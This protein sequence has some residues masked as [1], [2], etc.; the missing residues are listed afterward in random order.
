M[1]D[2]RFINII[3]TDN[4][5]FNTSNKEVMNI[6]YNKSLKNE[7]LYY[8]QII[9]SLRAWRKESGLK[10]SSSKY[11]IDYWLYNAYNNSEAEI[12]IKME[13]EKN[14]NSEYI[15]SFKNLD[16][17]IIGIK[18]RE[19]CKN[20]NFDNIAYLKDYYDYVGSD[21]YTSV[22]LTEKLRNY[23][24]SKRTKRGSELSKEFWYSYGWEFTDSE[25]TEKLKSIQKERSIWCGEFYETRGVD[26][27][28]S[29]EKISDYQKKNSDKRVKKYTSEELGEFSPLSKYYW[30]KKGYNEEDANIELRKRCPSNREFYSNDDDYEKRLKDIS[31]SMKKSW[32]NGSYDKSFDNGKNQSMEEI[33]FFDFISSVSDKITHIPFFMCI[34]NN[35]NKR[36]VY[37]GYYKSNDSKIILFEY[38]GL[39]YHDEDNDN[40]RDTNVF[41]NRTD[42]LGIIRISDKYYK[43]N[44]IKIRTEIYEAIR[45]I[46]NK[47]C[48]KIKLY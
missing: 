12:M 45:K 35:D 47:E 24:L 39:Y 32:S 10:I 38:D 19:D 27:E 36:Y 18:N 8:S 30:Y 15:S 48:K 16:E 17:F 43:K 2:K 33:E 13:Y 11:M 21:Y 28:T 41:E 25:L 9:K 44:K 20:I 34:K 1:I 26:K 29:I 46:E 4:A 22:R 3:I 42:I 31:I 14:N 6:I 23:I 7:K 40:I 37:D 5:N